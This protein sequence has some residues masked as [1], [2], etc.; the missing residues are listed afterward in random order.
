MM[1][2]HHGGG[3]TQTLLVKGT[4]REGSEGRMGGKKGRDERRRGLERA[5]GTDQIK[6]QRRA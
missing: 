3:R 4:K 1:R 6:N 5:N 2:G